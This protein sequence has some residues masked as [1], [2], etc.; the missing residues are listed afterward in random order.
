MSAEKTRKEVWYDVRIIDTIR[1]EL[2]HQPFLSMAF[3]LHVHYTHESQNIL[4]RKKSKKKATTKHQY[5]VLRI[6]ET[7]SSQQKVNLIRY[8]F[9][10]YDE[11]N[12][13]GWC[14]KG[15]STSDWPKKFFEWFNGRQGNL[16]QE[17]P[18]TLAI[19]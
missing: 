7:I 16:L 17:M 15:V 19:V 8:I 14:E 18:K 4:S 9:T 5:L 10:A 2:T 6:N 13:F 1:C 12:L 3:H 11:I